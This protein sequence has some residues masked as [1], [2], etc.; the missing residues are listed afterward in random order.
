[1]ATRI[2]Q[3]QE[4]WRG[5]HSSYTT[6]LSDPPTGLG[7]SSVAL[8]VTTPN[9]YYQLSVAVPIGAA[10]GSTYTITATA[11]GSQ[12]ADTQCVTMTATMQ[13][14]RMAYTPPVCWAN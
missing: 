4:R 3:A 1:M 14:G 5:D 13:G 9:G 12:T 8:S 6:D 2:Q 10:A 11:A 7:I